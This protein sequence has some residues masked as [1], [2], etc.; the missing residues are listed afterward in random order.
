MDNGRSFSV[1]ELVTAAYEAI[2]CRDPDKSGFLNNVKA[3]NF[4]MPVVDFFRNL[5]NSDEFAQKNKILRIDK[6]ELPDL[7]SCRPERYS[8]LDDGSTV[9]F[10]EADA[11][12]E[13]L[14]SSITNY[15]Y[16]D[17][18]GVWSPAI[19]LDKRLI[20]AIVAGLGARRSL[21]IGCFSGPVLIELNN[22][23]VDAV[24]IDI[25]HLA[26]VL[27]D[28][29]I[30]SKIFYGD[31][32][33]LNLDGRFDVVYGMDILE[34]LSPLKLGA[35][36]DKVEN[37][38]ADN[39]Y[40]FINSPIFGNDDIF[41]CVFSPYLPQWSST[42]G[43]SFWRHVHCDAKGWPLHGHLVWAESSWWED[44]FSERG[45]VRDREIER[46]IH[47]LLA[48]FFEHSAPAR[49]AFYVLKHKGNNL[50]NGRVIDALEREIGAV[51][52]GQSCDAE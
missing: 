9:Y 8:R 37:L 41:G 6:W 38:V 34:H 48:G 19:D 3:I 21:E 31:L 7:T 52:E 26:F 13:F 50:P 17:S 49:K 40:V 30:R 10:A 25:S 33:S 20:A 51:L 39:G 45:L 27:A 36:I 43:S 4:G 14:E 28:P 35:Y 12:F 23:G 18:L 44:I 24:G 32:L 22:R 11:D 1:E 16:Y 47:S 15:H 5:I 2:L 42:K 29:S 46:R